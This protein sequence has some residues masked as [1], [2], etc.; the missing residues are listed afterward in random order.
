MKTN[1]Q[2]LKQAK[3]KLK[4]D[5]REKF[6]TMSRFARMA[7]I[8]RYELQKIFARTYNDKE[9]RKLQRLYHKIQPRAVNGEIS[10]KQREALRLAIFM[11]GGV[12]AF[13]RENPEFSK[14]SIFQIMGGQR[15][16]MTKNVEKLFQKLK[17]NTH[18]QARN[19]IDQQAAGKD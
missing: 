4:A 8:D 17:I 15:R 16:L 7:K 12:T 5:I 19:G 18:E 14:V 10:E 6:R 9:V 3:D 13:V 1:A 2:Q 11:A